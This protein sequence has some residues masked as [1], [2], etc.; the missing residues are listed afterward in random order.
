MQRLIDYL[1]QHLMIDFQGELT[2]ARVRELLAGDDSRDAKA[3]M[4]KLVAEKRVEDM[5]L[6][7]ADCLLEHV[8]RSLTDDVVREQI[9][10]YT[11]S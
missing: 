6:V 9:R 10:M 5:M 2:V 7:L 8:Q 1:R 11:E 3:L 4:A